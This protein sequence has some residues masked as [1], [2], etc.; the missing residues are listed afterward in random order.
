M[1]EGT[2]HLP[3]SMSLDDNIRLIYVCEYIL[4]EII[5]NLL[6]SS[7]TPYEKALDVLSS[8]ITL[9]SPADKGSKCANFE[10]VFDYIKVICEFGDEQFSFVLGCKYRFCMVYGQL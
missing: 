6:M 5:L 10:L 1:E 7:V 4:Y 8:F 9:R 3:L 2:C